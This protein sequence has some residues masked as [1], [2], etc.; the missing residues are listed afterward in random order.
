MLKIFGQHDDN[1][2]QHMQACLD[3]G[4][5]HG[6]LC[7]DGHKGYSQPVGGVIGY[8]G[9][10]SVSGVGFDIAFGNMAC[11]T[12]AKLADVQPYIEMI[13]DDVFSQISFGV[14]RANN[15]PVDHELFDD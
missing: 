12:D 13:M 3:A 15:T 1:T 11:K 9:R 4:G 14:G 10:I 6:V 2:I 8:E 7:A 5:G